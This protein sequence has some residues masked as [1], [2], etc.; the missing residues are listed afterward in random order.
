M[1]GDGVWIGAQ[2]LVGPGVRIGAETVV[3]AGSLVTKD[4]PAGLICGGNPL[5]EKKA[6]WS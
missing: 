5:Q 2:V 1:I 4:V 6:R 3:Q